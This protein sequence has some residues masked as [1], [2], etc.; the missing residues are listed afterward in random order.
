MM[1]DP[2]TTS[3]AG[4]ET[5]PNKTAEM[6]GTTIMTSDTAGNVVTRSRLDDIDSS[7]WSSLEQPGAKDIVD[8]LAKPTLLAS[9]N[10]T[11]T[12]SGNFQILNLPEAFFS[13]ARI[14]NK[15]SG[16][17]MIRADIVLTLQVNAVRFQQ[18]RYVLAYVP[19]GGL[20][21]SNSGAQAFF[22][23]H[24]VN[25][26][27]VSQLPHV[28]IDLATQTTAELR[29]PYSSIYPYVKVANSGTYMNSL[30]IV[31][32]R[33]YS[34]LQAGAGDTT[35]GY[36]LM[37]RMENVVLTGN[38]LPQSGRR[39]GFKV[40][41]PKSVTRTE[42]E[43]P[44]SGPVSGILNTISEGTAVLSRLPILGGILG[45]VSWAS[46]I[47][48]GAAAAFG[49]SKPLLLD[50]V[51]RFNRT[52][53]PF[54]GTADGFTPAMP[55]ALKSDNEVVIHSGVGRTDI[56]EMS[57]DFIKQ[58]YAYYSTTT[59]G[60]SATSG[61]ILATFYHNPLMYYTSLGVNGVVQTPIAFLASQFRVWRGGM[62]FKI[63]LVKTEFHSGRLILAYAPYTGISATTP[64]VDTSTYL[65]REIVDVRDTT[66]VEICV[67]YVIP[68][69][70]MP[71]YYNSGSPLV[72]SAGVFYILVG[73]PL[74]APNMTNNVNLIVEV[75]AA[76][77]FEFAIPCAYDKKAIIPF[78]TQSGKLKDVEVGRLDLL[79]FQSSY[80]KH[81]CQVF[82]LDS[83]DIAASAVAIGEKAE[84]LRQLI[85]RVT[86]LIPSGGT[87]PV[88]T[89][90][91]VFT[92]SAFA[93][94]PVFET[95]SIGGTMLEDTWVCDF[96]NTL[97]LCYVYNNG[98]MRYYIPPVQS[99]KANMVSV[100]VDRDPSKYQLATQAAFQTYTPV[101]SA[102]IQI[103]T[104]NDDPPHVTVPAYNRM[105]GRATAAQ[106]VTSATLYSSPPSDGLGQ[107]TTSIT[108]QPIDPVT[109]T[110]SYRPYKYCGDDYSM[111]YWIGTVP[112]I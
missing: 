70:Y 37:G 35:C 82:G 61:T 68:E 66:E 94:N 107:N 95:G 39:V 63:K 89:A 57:L 43:N 69:L 85:K 60:T 96:I 52:G 46:D 34:A 42:Q 25:M 16:V 65:V 50:K 6:A 19:T 32:L 20:L 18:G 53:F 48:A 67:P 75:S 105:I 72:N 21:N 109:A 78:A 5:A 14:S 79:K 51:S 84:S 11:T 8:F 102:P 26:T 83:T 3:G 90:G 87:F 12:D 22:R 17:A 4:Y 93:I 7:I 27:S 80:L 111:S 101:R 24:A 73:D 49:F 36:M 100:T 13:N 112:V 104:A 40:I 9:G 81:E 15:L 77:D 31:F 71:A 58:Q 91:Q 110:P 106:I 38:I 64:G 47:L 1:T 103:F 41:K 10:F 86:P 74:V 45:N 92:I 99:T 97:S 54:M 33:P 55:L 23:A 76:P 59:W 2:I 98:G 108:V 44:R 28:E 56:D 29:I 62:K 88:G 30:G